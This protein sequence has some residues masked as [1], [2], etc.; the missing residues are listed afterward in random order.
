M[1]HIAAAAF[2]P[3]SSNTSYQHSVDG[4]IYYSTNNYYGWFVANLGLPPGAE[5]WGICTYFYDTAP[6]ESVHTILQAVK[7]A[8]GSIGPGVIPIY[9]PFSVDYDGG[10]GVSCSNSSYILRDTGDID[11]DGA[12]EDVV[13]R[14]RVE[15][16]EDGSGTLG[17]G[18]VRVFWRRKV[19]PAPAAA[20]FGDAPPSHPFFQFIEALAAS[21]ITG[22]CGRRELLPRRAA[23]ARP[24]GGVPLQGA[25]A[26]LV[27]LIEACAGES[28][29]R[30]AGRP[31]RKARGPGGVDGKKRASFPGYGRR[32]RL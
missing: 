12:N 17:F 11:G 21:G 19:S 18:G 15:M 6:G 27:Q 8:V 30:S 32:A 14:L 1:L 25:G 29:G 7:L 31:V 4:Y 24:D 28:T 23:D 5:I 9:G 26:A 13:H 16:Y 20:T 2:Q 3:V 10:Y 22:G